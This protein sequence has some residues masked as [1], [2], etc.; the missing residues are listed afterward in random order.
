MLF[1][2]DFMS[3][4]K[5]DNHTRVFTGIIARSNY[6]NLRVVLDIELLGLSSA[7]EYEDTE[8]YHPSRK[9]VII[10]DFVNKCKN[11][12]NG[13]PTSLGVMISSL[14]VGIK[15]AFTG[16]PYDPYIKH[17]KDPL[18]IADEDRIVLDN[19]YLEVVGYNSTIARN[20]LKHQ[21]SQEN[22]QK[23][24]EKWRKKFYGK[25]LWARLSRKMSIF[26]PK[27]LRHVLTIAFIVVA[28]IFLPK[29]LHQGIAIEVVGSIILIL[30][31]PLFKK[32]Q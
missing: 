20:V 21:V 19:Q 5:L 15:I 3:R 8:I 25:T 12:P 10:S 13:I 28:L 11:N 26:L 23:H 14:P 29:W 7:K 4:L 16:K 22:D 30:L 9:V 2:S 31:I 17:V 6:G 27:W 18:S 1:C 24:H 32:S